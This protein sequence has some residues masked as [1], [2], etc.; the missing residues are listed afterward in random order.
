MQS[1]PTWAERFLRIICPEQVVDQII[2]DLIELYQHDIKRYGQ[3]KARWKLIITALRF[4]R[5]AILIRNKFSINFN[6]GPMVQHYLKT[7]FRHF[8]K[9]KLNF[10]FKLLG[11]CFALV[12]LLVIV[13]YL[14]FQLS[15]DKFHEDYQHIYRVNSQWRENGEM[16]KYALVPT[17]VGPMLKNEFPE[18]R[19]YARM[20]GASRCQVRVKDKSFHAE[21]IAEADS[22]LFN[23]L[24]FSFIRGDKHALQKPRS[25]VLTE[26]LAKQIF[27]DADPFEE[28]ITLVDRAGVSLQVTGIIKDLPPNSHLSIKALAS[29]GSLSDSSYVAAGSWDISID[30]STVL[31][32]RL[33]DGSGAEEFLSKAI[34]SVKKKITRNESGLEKEYGIL[35]QPLKD[36]YLDRPIYAEF[37]VK[38]NIVYIYMFAVL[39]LFLLVISGINYINLTVAD[40]HKRLKEI[41][42]RKVMGALKRQ[43]AFQVIFEGCLVVVLSL[44]VSICALYLL[45]PEVQQLLDPN[46]KF[47]ML[48]K[49]EIIAMLAAVIGLLIILSTLYPA[50]QLA[51]NSPIE[52]MK[53]IG[54]PGSHAKIG[55]VLLI[56]QFG[57]SMYA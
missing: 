16:A 24:S 57:I 8:L 49:P 12:S 34:P 5:P 18:V 14:S 55:R 54:K 39:G 4:F 29:F 41:G 2:G 6:H 25:I 22:T 1:F 3:Q 32:L 20:G 21:G 45:F 47:V 48:A 53:S 50:Y 28:S 27:D 23:V 51:I 19:G 40:F 31:Y 15:F 56:S 38:G 43:I 37:C 10:S 33:S 44:I 13:L 42:I 35:L 9:S 30:G 36:I 52:N 11:L 17:G 46:L 26:S 7:S